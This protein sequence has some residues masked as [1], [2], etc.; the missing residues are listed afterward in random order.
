MVTAGSPHFILQHV[1]GTSYVLELC[2]LRLVATSEIRKLST[3]CTLS[4]NVYY[5]SYVSQLYLLVHSKY[6]LRKI[7]NFIV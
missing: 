7:Y 2:P 5:N 1:G 4:T 3:A 6:T